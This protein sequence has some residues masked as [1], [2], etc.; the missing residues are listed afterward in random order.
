MVVVLLFLLLS[1]NVFIPTSAHPLVFLDKWFAQIY[2]NVVLVSA[3][4]NH[5]SL[6]YFESAS[7]TFNYLEWNVKRG[8]DCTKCCFLVSS[9]YIYLAQY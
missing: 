1:F 7:I 6:S 2:L 9:N 8:S 4:H 5:N 3:T